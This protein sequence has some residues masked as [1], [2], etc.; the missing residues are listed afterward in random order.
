M[1]IIQ[2]L[3]TLVYGDA[4]SNEVFSIDKL[5]YE[6]GYTTVICCDNYNDKRV[7]GK[8]VS[9]RT[10]M[11]ILK[12]E[13]IVIYHLCIGTELSYF[14]KK[15]KCKKGVIYHN[16]TPH[17]FFEKYSPAITEVTK[18]GRNTL[19]E[20]ANSVDFAFAD[21]LYNKTE[22]ECYGYKNTE[23]LPILI[24]FDNYKGEPDKTV[25]RTYS[26][27]KKNILFVGRVAPN[28]KHED[29]ILAYDYYKKNIDNNCRLLLV[30]SHG[31]ESYLRDLKR[32][33]NQMDI[34]DVVFT[35]HVK[36]EELI[37]YYRV[38]DVFLCMSEHEGFCVPL[39]ESMYFNVPIIAYNSSAIPDTLNK[40]FIIFNK[41]DYAR[42]SFL[43]YE[44]LYN[45][46]LRNELIIKQQE[47]LNDFSQNKI[48]NILLNH[49][50]RM[51]DQ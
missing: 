33:V 40:D 12:P 5:L 25:V 17:Q 48:S 47:R 39:I 15:L 7:K 6:N 1:K 24:D 20:I 9:V 30:G 32:L 31:I 2:L 27:G 14:F 41:K 50:Q 42:L 44:V 35:G 51:S 11:S 45:N 16:I 36:I 37:A 49:I 28:K 34:E 29:I 22:L 3:E 8:V 26:D 43:L 4:I 10:L 38:A 19:R 13:D 18:F 21:S 46:E 23:V